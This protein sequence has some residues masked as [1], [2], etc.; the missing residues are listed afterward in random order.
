MHAKESDLPRHTRPS[1]LAADQPLIV[2]MLLK[3]SDLKLRGIVVLVVSKTKG[4]TLVFKND[5][6]E[7][8]LVSST[9]DSVTSVRNFLQREIEHQL[10]NLFQE[11]LPVMIHNLSLRHIQLE[12]EKLNSSSRQQHFMD[13]NRTVFSDPGQHH[14]PQQLPMDTFSMPDLS[15]DEH[16]PLSPTYSNSSSYYPHNIPVT[17]ANLSTLNELY[18]SRFSALKKSTAT[19]S[20]EATSFLE[21]NTASSS[22]HSIVAAEMYADSDDAPWYMTEGPELPTYDDNSTTPLTI[23]GEEEGSVITVD[24][25]DNMVAA[26]LA[27]LTT[28]HHTISPFAHT[29]HHSTFRSLPHTVKIADTTKLKNNKKKPKRRI[30]RLKSNQ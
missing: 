19:S 17:A 10:R 18:S 12:Q 21:E 26:K 1:V 14:Q 13:S 25:N 24:P 23:G 20:Y 28:I 15:L 22:I 8:I 16:Y 4:I 27:R 9:F 30:I 5:P 6:L 29:I 2:P 11:D 3:I 7:S